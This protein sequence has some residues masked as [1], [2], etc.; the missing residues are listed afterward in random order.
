[1]KRFMAAVMV[2]ATVA[3]AE[4]AS[5]GD[6]PVVDRVYREIAR[7][8]EAYV[9]SQPAP[10][11][12][13]GFLAYWDRNGDGIRMFGTER[14]HFLFEKCMRDAEATLVERGAMEWVR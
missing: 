9:N 2:A 10:P 13:P 7:T 5:A 8:C 12:V 11:G 6:D 4:T 14:Q 1:M 3:T